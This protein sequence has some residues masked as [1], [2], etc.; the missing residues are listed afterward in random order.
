MG[1]T[2]RSAHPLP[3]LTAGIGAALVCLYAIFD[4]ETTWWMPKC[5]VRFFTGLD[6]PGCG[7]QRAIHALLHGELYEALG[8]NAML[9]CL[10]P[11]LALMAYAEL[12]HTRH[13]RLYRLVT[14][15][16]LIIGL[17]VV[18]L[19]WGVCRNLDFFA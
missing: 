18:I 2:L 5:P 1:N 13:P 17:L 3:L 6:C 9:V 11:M 10:L 7:S 14:Y 8:H 4:P 16:G 19:A 12:T 15:P